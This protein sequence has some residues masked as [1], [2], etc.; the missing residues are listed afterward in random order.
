MNE[1]QRFDAWLAENRETA[2]AV[3][4]GLHALDAAYF[5][6]YEDAFDWSPHEYRDLWGF[7]DVEVE[8]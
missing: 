8:S 1:Q 5:H 6:E 7:T 2:L 3:C 4:R